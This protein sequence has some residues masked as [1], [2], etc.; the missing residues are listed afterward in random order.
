MALNRFLRNL[1]FINDIMLRLTDMTQ[2]VI[3]LPLT[4][5]T[6][7]QSPSG[8]CGNRDEVILGEVPPAA[9]RF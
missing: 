1:Q 4:A 3:L 8:I 5:E 6:W 2:A 9:L 7:F